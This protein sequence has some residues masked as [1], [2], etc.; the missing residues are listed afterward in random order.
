MARSSQ[1]VR[2]LASVGGVES[3]GVLLIGVT[4]L[5]IV[6]WLPKEQYAEYTFLIACVTL[7]LGATDLGLVHCVLPIVGERSTDERWVVGVTRRVF[8]KRI[9]LLGLGLALVVPYWFAVS[10]RHDWLGQSQYLLAA[11]VALCVVPLTLREHY[12]STILIILRRISRLNRVNLAG[13]LVRAGCVLALVLLTTSSWSLVGVM[14]ATAVGLLVSVGLHLRALRL[15]RLD[16]V[17]LDGAEGKAVDQ[18]LF[19]LAKPLIGPSVYYQVQ[20]TIT[21]LLIASFGASD[22]IADL[23]AVTRLALVMVVLDRVLNVLLFPAIARSEVGAELVSI[24]RRSTLTYAAGGVIVVLSALALPQYWVVILGSQYSG[25]ESVVWFVVLTSFLQG[26]AGFLFRTLTARGATRG[27]S[28][29]VPILIAVQVAY[30]VV[31]GVHDLRSVLGLALAASATAVVFQLA[32]TVRAV[33]TWRSVEPS[34][35]DSVAPV[36]APDQ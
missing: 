16:L 28:W 26:G 14:G 20:G 31:V 4:G 24:V 6:N 25:V 36:E 29:S 5:L 30:I 32:F 10:Q 34:G 33:R 7:I 19:H 8:A 11:A 27:Q 9:W 23:G 17:D 3:V 15:E 18:Q 21:V 1:R 2:Q 22:S 35:V 12:T 13:Y